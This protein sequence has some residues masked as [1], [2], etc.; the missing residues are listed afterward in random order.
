MGGLLAVKPLARSK[1]GRR[2]KATP[3]RNASRCES[4]KLVPLVPEVVRRPLTAGPTKVPSRP[5][6]RAWRL[7]AEPPGF[8]RF[9]SNLIRSAHPAPCVLIPRSW[10]VI[11]QM[12]QNRGGILG[13][14]CTRTAGST[15]PLS[16]LCNTHQGCGKAAYSCIC[17]GDHQ[18][19]YPPRHPVSIRYRVTARNFGPSC[20]RAVDWVG[21][22]PRWRGLLVVAAA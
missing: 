11:L 18:S 7:A 13:V 12:A 20:V 1:R 15:V 21:D 9:P 2:D 14:Q 17:V 3:A 6:P 19:T 22:A 5:T 8:P 4:R 10:F 16:C